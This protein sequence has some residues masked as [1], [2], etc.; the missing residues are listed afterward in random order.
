MELQQLESCSRALLELPEIPPS[1]LPCSFPGPVAPPSGNVPPHPSVHLAPN[2]DCELDA[3]LASVDIAPSD[4][5]DILSNLDLSEAPVGPGI[6]DLLAQ[7][8]DPATSQ[9]ARESASLSHW[10]AAGAATYLEKYYE[11]KFRRQECEE[12]ID[13]LQKELLTLRQNTAVL[14][15]NGRRKDATILK[16]SEA[17]K[18]V[19]SEWKTFEGTTRSEFEALKKEH[20]S[21]SRETD[22]DREKL[23]ELETQLQRATRIGEDFQDQLRLKEGQV[24]EL[25]ETLASLTGKVGLV[26]DNCDKIRVSPPISTL[27]PKS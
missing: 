15:G 9:E 12:E 8:I 5:E 25:E 17:W 14:Q 27:V 10:A 26:S 19:S 7:I 2:L 20:A 18:S 11:E 1:T 22:K 16:I 23:E 21:L 3:L 6:D 13:K 24:K 4:F